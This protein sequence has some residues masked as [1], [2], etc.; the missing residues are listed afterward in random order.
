[1]HYIR[2]F[3]KALQLTLRGETI[4][5][6]VSRYP[7][8]QAWLSIS[9]KKLEALYSQTE[10]NGLDEST[11]KQIILKLDGRSWSMELILATVKFH[12]ETEFPS[13]MSSVID[14]NLTTLYAVHF[15]D[16]YR[17]SQLAQSEQLPENFRETMRDFVAHFEAIPSSNEP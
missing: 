7:N 1:M 15:D 9:Q 13:L 12:L 4:D 10:K 8:L 11:R 14:H 6:P 3:F 16:K 5:A 2:T 17:V